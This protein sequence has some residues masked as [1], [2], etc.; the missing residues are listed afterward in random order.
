MK[1]TLRRAFIHAAIVGL[2]AFAGVTYAQN[3]EPA[4]PPAPPPPN[5]EVPD[6]PAAAPTP[7][8]EAPDTDTP[9]TDDTEVRFPRRHSSQN[10]RV[11]V[12]NDAT[13]EKGQEADAV[14]SVFGNSTSEGD[15]SDAVVS[16]LGN[17]R[18]PAG[19]A[20][21]VIAV[22]GN[23]YLNTKASG[24]VVATMGSV[25]L[26]PEAEVGGD[27]VVVGG[28]LKRDPRAI[29]HG[30]VNQILPISIGSF[31]W[32]QPWTRKCL[33]YFRPLAIAPGLGWAWALALGFLALYVL[34][35]VVSRN[36]VDR[37][38]RTFETQ[39]GKCIVAALLTTVLTPIVFALLFVTIIG[40]A[41]LPFA[42]L[43]LFLMSLFGKAIMLAWIGRSCLRLTDDGLKLHTAIQILLGGAVVLVLYLVPFVGFIVYKTLG[44]LGLGVA[45]YALILSMRRRGESGPPLATAEGSV[46]GGSSSFSA[47]PMAGDGESPPA[48]NYASTS[49]SGQQPFIGE[50]FDERR[51]TGETGDWQASDESASSAERATGTTGFGDIPGSPAPG[52]TSGTSGFAG[53]SDSGIGGGATGEAGASSTAGGAGAASHGAGGASGTSRPGAPGGSG[54]APGAGG[55]GRPKGP[56]SAINT[57]AASTYPRAGFG[58]RMA[59]LFIDVVLVSVLL[60]IVD[61]TK[62]AQLIALATYGAVMWKLKATTIGGIVFGLQVVRVDGQPIDWATATVRALSCF[63]SLVVAGLGFI[64]I[65]FDEGHQ[66]WH[67]KIA[68]TAVVRVPKGVSLL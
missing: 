61:S 52:G 29:V 56:A 67:D 45:V 68:G 58:V 6:A 32:L 22:L 40:I 59:A 46:A 4:A 63:L 8:V 43:A 11:A 5:V 49:G 24:D 62:E 1:H 66:G 7:D 47:A 23:V 65:A 20:K 25:E 21:D 53:S 13:L 18:V 36:S 50:G 51:A 15:V 35:G 12:G 9:N 10:E 3:T 57:A 14:V 19:S 48:G 34:I 54:G 64:W 44:F 31:E 41:F 42:V 2:C 30:A 17:T 37:A 16:V 27:V 60:G 38:V 26:G 33:L 39:P 55:P 28:D